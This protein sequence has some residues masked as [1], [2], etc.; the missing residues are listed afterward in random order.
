MT[1]AR[2]ACRRLGHADLVARSRFACPSRAFRATAESIRVSRTAGKTRPQTFMG[3]NTNAPLAPDL[4]GLCGLRMRGRPAAA[5]RSS[6]S[7]SC[8]AT[9]PIST[10]APSPDGT[11]PAAAARNS[12]LGTGALALGRS[13]IC[14]DWRSLR[15]TS[16]RTA[17]GTTALD[18]GR[19]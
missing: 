15:R 14:V 12:G 10:A 19:P 7:R 2:W 17:L 3:E 18:V 4:R 11:R 1:A 9:Q 13:P 8:P 5:T 6:G 16:G